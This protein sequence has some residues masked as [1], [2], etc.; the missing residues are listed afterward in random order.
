[1]RQAILFEPWWRWYTRS[2]RPASL[3]T[4]TLVRCCWWWRWLRRTE[5]D[6]WRVNGFK[7]IIIFYMRVMVYAVSEGN[8]IPWRW[9]HV[10]CTRECCRVICRSSCLDRRILFMDEEYLV[11]KFR[12]QVGFA[13][14]WR[15]VFWNNNFFFVNMKSDDERWYP[16]DERTSDAGQEGGDAG[17]LAAAIEIRIPG[18]QNW[19]CHL[20]ASW[21]SQWDGMDGFYRSWLSAAASWTAI[22]C[23]EG[24]WLK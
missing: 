23:D 19:G 24:R 17:G 6:G 9:R 11:E 22:G 1:M 8:E 4:G 15:D 21:V 12:R 18:C 13:T 20:V 3:G 10:P 2:G 7:K 14:R 16:A 5:V